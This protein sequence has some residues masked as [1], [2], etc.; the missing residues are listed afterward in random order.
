M[1]L[2]HSQLKKYIPDLDMNAEEAA[3]VFTEIGY[4]KDG[5]IE[6][7]EYLGKKDSFTDLE[8][9]QNRADCF[10]VHGLA[11]EIGAYLQLDFKP[12][13]AS[14]LKNNDLPELPIEIK[15]KESVKRVM[16]V[17]IDDLEIKE[18]PDWLKEYLELYEINSINTLV[19]LTNYVML[20]TS[21]PSHAFDA[22]LSGDALVW[23]INPKYKKMT[24]LDGTEIDLSEDA[25]VVSDGKDPLALAGLVGG[26]KAAMDK[27]S[28]SVIVEMAVYDGGL[29]RRN[30]RTMKVFTEASSRLEK[31]MDPESVDEAFNWLI[32]M[33]LDLC[34]GKL[35]SKGY[36]NYLQKEDKVE[37]EVDLEKGNQIAGVEIDY[38]EAVGYLEKLGFTIL[39][40][41]LPKLTVIKP[42]NRLD[43]E[44][45][46]D[47]FEEI[48]RMYGYFNLPTD[49][50][51]VNVTKNIT[52]THIKLI[53]ETKSFLTSNGYDEIRSWVLV[54]DEKNEK[55]NYTETEAV[56]VQNSI[57]EGVPTVRQT[58]TPGII[59]QI[60]EYKKK[61]INDI[62]IFE[63]GKVFNQTDGVFNEYYSLGGAS[64]DSSLDSVQKLVTSYLGSIGIS[65]I[66]FVES[67]KVP[68]YAHPKTCFDLEV[69]S[70]DGFVKAG[71]IY[72]F[73]KNEANS[74]G[75]YFELNINSLDEVI[76]NSKSNNST[77]ELN[78]KLVNLDTNVE[79]S[80]DP[81]DMI[82][83][84]IAD[85]LE[86]IWAWE[87]IDEYEGKYTVRITYYNLSDQEAKALHERLF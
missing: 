79:S 40:N 66:K 15:A 41:D 71:I 26:E 21:H 82:I 3:R 73:N 57:N 8:V 58:V 2:L 13:V 29:I 14:A 86:N 42:I 64:V 19:D 68:T 76:L 45:E 69:L 36:D 51:K 50:L 39:K 83:E 44:E 53:D 63:I 9:R 20:E 37:I 59:S 60:E 56:R 4:M 6:E 38:K 10:G 25:L 35:A 49:N 34:G 43:I 61:F 62:R 67:K 70:N 28:K 1:K 52:P 17:K 18:S 87:I 23:E 31:F 77:A 72:V 32:S 78:S 7:V 48:I 75:V 33:I 80:E 55:G 65:A 12:E 85:N 16:A 74:E 46:A 11:R 22:K 84:K 30:S 24:S 81:T 5:D 54:D 47:V 27:N